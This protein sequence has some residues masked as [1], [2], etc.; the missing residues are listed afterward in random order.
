MATRLIIEG[1]MDSLTVDEP[2][3]I[4]SG[5][6]ALTS[7][8]IDLDPTNPPIYKLIGASGVLLLARPAA[9][10]CRNASAVFTGDPQFI[11]RVTLAA[12]LPIIGI[13][14]LLAMVVYLWT[15]RLFGYTAALL[16]LGI[17]SLEPTLLAHAHLVTGDLTLTFGLTACLAAHWFWSRTQ[18]VRWLVVCGIALGLALLSR[19]SALEFVPVLAFAGLVMASGSWPSRIRSALRSFVIVGAAAWG[20][21][22]ITYLPFSTGFGRFQWGAPPSWVA[23]PQWFDSLT[24]Q[25]HHVQV[26]HP[27][28]LNGHL[29]QTHGFWGYFLEAFALKTTLGLLLL[30]V[31]AAVWTVWLRDRIV[32]LYIWLPIVTVVLVATIGGIDIGVRYLLPVYPLAAIAAGRVVSDLS[33]ASRL[34]QAAALIAFVALALSSLAHAPNDIGYFNELAGSN[35]EAYLSD[36]NV[37][38]GQDAWRLKTW[39]ESNGR[40]P[41]ATNV[42]SGL[43]LEAYGISSVDTQSEQVPRYLAISVDKVTNSA[44]WLLSAEPAARIGTSI[45]IYKVAG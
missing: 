30:M 44:R 35:P 6:C 34:S 40:P 4:E 23:P 19:V 3:Y 39:W 7:R 9:V 14:L 13:A 38:W 29:A 22:C 41:M 33:G 8:V 45:W 10:D 17:V 31:G 28:Y 21:V 1:Q 12:R 15:R 42:F 37:D 32:L 18:H 11:Q 2:L 26:G 36:S 27:A 20:T 24:Y 16:A 43:P 5:L 25:I